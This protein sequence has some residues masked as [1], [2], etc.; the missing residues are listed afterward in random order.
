M[1]DIA[2]YI[3]PQ[4]LAAGPD[5]DEAKEANSKYE[6]KYILE[7]R[8]DFAPA[9]ITLSSGLLTRFPNISIRPPPIWTPM[10]PSG[11]RMPGWS[12]QVTQ[13]PFR[14]HLLMSTSISKHRFPL[15]CLVL[16]LAV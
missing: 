7:L 16:L 2:N 9:D 12:S 1:Q 6:L 13:L 14:E 4:T 11:G 8:E 3:V 5:E 15:P 10:G